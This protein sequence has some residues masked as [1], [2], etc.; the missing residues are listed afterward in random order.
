[1]TKETGLSASVEAL[2]NLNKESALDAADETG[3]QGDVKAFKDTRV[4][5]KLGVTTTLWKSLSLGLGF[6]L[7]YD[8]NPAP[9]PIPGS[10]GGAKYVA[11]YQPFANKMDTLTEATLIFTFL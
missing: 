4:I 2:F 11:G 3:A 9:R 5:G 8:Q 6:T 1:M 7:K 10:A